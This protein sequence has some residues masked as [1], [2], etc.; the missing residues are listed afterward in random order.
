MLDKENEEAAR[1]LGQ[2]LRDHLGELLPHHREAIEMLVMRDPPLKFREAAAAQGVSITTVRYRLERG[3][4]LLLEAVK[5][6]GELD[7]PGDSDR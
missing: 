3:L 4:K 5:A 2:A 7:V 6:A 1:R